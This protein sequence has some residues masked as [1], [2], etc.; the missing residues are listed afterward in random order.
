MFMA[1]TTLS[2]G[3]QKKYKI[4]DYQP[5]VVSEEEASASGLN[6]E[7]AAEYIQTTTAIAI[8]PLLVVGAKGLTKW[9]KTPAD[10]RSSLSFIN[11]PWVWGVFLGIGIFF[12][13]NSFIG[14]LIPPLKKPMD[15]IEPFEH[16]VSGF[17]IGLPIVVS[18]VLS[19]TQSVAALFAG[20][21]SAVAGFIL[22]D[23]ASI[24]WASVAL[25]TVVWTIVV[26]ICFVSVWSFSQFM[27]LLIVLSPWGGI[28]LGLRICKGIV[29]VA[30]IVAGFISPWLSIILCGAI[31]VST[32][33][34]LKIS[35]R[36]SRYLL[37]LISDF[38]FG[39]FRPHRGQVREV[40][41]CALTRI[42]KVKKRTV[43]IL[44]FY[45][46]GKVRF[47]HFGGNFHELPAGLELRDEFLGG[48]VLD[49]TK[50]KNSYLFR[51]S[52]RYRL[53]HIEVAQRLQL[54][55]SDP[56]PAAQLVRADPNEGGDYKLDMRSQKDP[57]GLSASRILGYI[58][59]RFGSYMRFWCQF[60][61]VSSRANG[62]G[63]R[64]YSRG[65]AARQKSL[66]FWG[67]IADSGRQAYQ[68]KSATSHTQT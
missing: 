59:Y 37:Y 66:G 17:L 64:L 13:I 44:D 41:A 23:I 33:L 46:D 1:L 48:V 28:D 62:D 22:P 5:P 29:L 7:K 3:A 65:E 43:G 56:D 49:P 2:F 24:S 20:S 40:K 38:V 31:I 60:A 30:I 57:S 18:M 42:E 15:L 68:G 52:R 51:I 50:E 16:I 53:R 9:Y 14:T 36:A 67:M 10:Q 21:G 12:I 39:Q 34:A 26:V 47:R 4:S 55:Y 61:E 11:R 8:S 19:S 6:F 27:N 54:A 63:K 25:T 35:L 58:K 45:D 32:L